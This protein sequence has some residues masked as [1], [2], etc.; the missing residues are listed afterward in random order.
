MKRGF[1]SGQLVDLDEI[2]AEIYKN[3]ASYKIVGESVKVMNDIEGILSFTHFVFTRRSSVGFYHR[4][5]SYTHAH[6][7]SPSIFPTFVHL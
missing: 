6:F 1:S 7:F 5:T 4:H 2:A 3:E